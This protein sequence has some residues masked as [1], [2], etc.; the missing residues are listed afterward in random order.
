[1]QTIF[2]LKREITDKTDTDKKM[3][4]KISSLIEAQAAYQEMEPD[5]P[6]LTQALPV[7]SEVPRAAW[8]LQNLATDMHV[9]A[10]NLS[11]ITVPLAPDAGPGGQQKTAPNKLSDFPVSLSVTGAYPDIKNFIQGIGNLRRIIQTDSML[12]TPIRAS[13]TTATSSATPAT[14]TGTQIKLD[15]K[16]KVFYL[17]S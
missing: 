4:D 6:L 10:T 9:T 14:P 1:M 7:N 11:I 15:L 13:G 17:S 12:F 16:L 3:E 2:T 5:L 8:E